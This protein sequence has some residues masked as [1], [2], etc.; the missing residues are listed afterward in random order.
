MKHL[1][2]NQI[3]RRSHSLRRY[4]AA[5]GAPAL[6][7]ALAALAASPAAADCSAGPMSVSGGPGGLSYTCTRNCMATGGARVL[8]TRTFAGHGV[9]ASQ[10]T[11]ACNSTLGCV[12]VNYTIVVSMRDGIPYS[13]MT[14]TLYGTGEL[15]TADAS[16]STPGRY[17][18]V[19]YRDPPPGLWRDPRL[20]IDT[21]VLQ[22]DHIRPGLPGISVPHS[23]PN[24]P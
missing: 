20:Q 12:A 1:A 21:R 14:C 22:Q 4:G 11:S 2:S 8:G 24:K 10:C 5:L 13:E 16:P 3:A 15:S 7:L 9:T 18:G 17:G 23:N 6:G 19:C